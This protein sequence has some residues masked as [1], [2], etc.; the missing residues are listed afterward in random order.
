MRVCLWVCGVRARLCVRVH[1]CVCVR[2]LVCKRWL[3]FWPGGAARADLP[4][5]RGPA[6]CRHARLRNQTAATTATNSRPTARR[7]GRFPCC[8]AA[9]PCAKNCS[10][11]VAACVL[12]RGR[13]QTSAR[14]RSHHA[15]RRLWMCCAAVRPYAAEAAGSSTFRFF[16]AF[17]RDPPAVVSFGGLG[18][19]GA[20]LRLG[21]R[22][23][24][25]AS[26]AGN[27]RLLSSLPKRGE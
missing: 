10:A 27:E 24:A 9:R 23:A 1:V 25:A 7:V 20:A 6:H 14:G 15:A 12:E 16:A 4:L 8:A 17:A 13:A 21:P 11:A 5:P 3:L 26:N 22:A 2:A 19:V 18:R